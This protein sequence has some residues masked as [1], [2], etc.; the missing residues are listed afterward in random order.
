MCNTA[1][2]LPLGDY[3]NRP[4]TS[5][6][7]KNFSCIAEEL[8]GWTIYH[9]HAVDCQP[10]RLISYK[11]KDA[12]KGDRLNWTPL[13]YAAQVGNL[14]ST[15]ALLAAGAPANVRAIDGMTPLHVAALHGWTAIVRALD[16][17]R[18]AKGERRARHIEDIGGWRPLRWAAR[19]KHIRSVRILKRSVKSLPAH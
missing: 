18:P 4:G 3:D 5:M 6:D 17:Q 13:H 7:A 1:R 8:S 9:Y 15:R 2:P 11:S 14:T 19:G 16:E 12:R 10:N